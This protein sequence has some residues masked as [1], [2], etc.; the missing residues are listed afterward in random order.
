MQ[1]LLNEG[2][3]LNEKGEL[4]EAGYNTRLIKKYDRRRIKASCLRI[5]E[6]DYYYIGN[7]HYAVA[8][9]I[10]D[11]SYMSLLSVSFLDFDNKSYI[12]KSKMGLLPFGKTNLPSTSEKGDITLNISSCSLKFINETTKRHLIGTFKKFDGSNDFSCDIELLDMP[13]DSMVIAI[14]FDKLP[15]H[16]YYNQKINCLIARGEFKI[17]NKTYS[18]NNNSSLG[19]QDWGRGVWPYKSSWYWASLSTYDVYGRKIGLNL[20]YGFGNTT[21]ATEN[22][23]FVDGIHTKLDDIVFVF[24][25]DEKGN[26]DLKNQWKIISKNRDVDITFEPILDRVDKMSIG[27]ISTNQHQ[28]FGKMKGTIKI[29][30]QEKITLT[31]Q[32]GFSE[33]ISHKW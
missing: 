16:F 10:A 32:I 3:L 15:K 26:R 20:G 21:N 30:D 4:C 13:K 14:P 25:N 1:N 31:G 8:L 28:I 18:F 9:T 27:I 5:K 24:Q 23:L 22:M 19:V 17:G 11:N 12:T 2:D 6:W 29:S 7:E 33:V